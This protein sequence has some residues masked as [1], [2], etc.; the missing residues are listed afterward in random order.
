M[1]ESGEKERGGD[2]DGD[3]KRV[4]I[5]MNGVKVEEGKKEDRLRVQRKGRERDKQ[6]AARLESQDTISPHKESPFL[7]LS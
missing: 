4:E 2:G 1:A 3:G 6:G 7:P 5:E